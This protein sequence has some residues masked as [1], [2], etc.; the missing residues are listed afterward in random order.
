MRSS[1][2]LKTVQVNESNRDYGSNFIPCFFYTVHVRLL[3]IEYPVMTVV[4]SWRGIVRGD[5]LGLV[6]KLDAPTFVTYSSSF[7]SETFLRH[8]T[9]DKVVFFSKVRNVEEMSS[10]LNLQWV[11]WLKLLQNLL[12]NFFFFFF[13]FLWGQFIELWVVTNGY[14]DFQKE[15][16][17]FSN[18]FGREK[19]FQMFLHTVCVTIYN[20]FERRSVFTFLPVNDVMRKHLKSKVNDAFWK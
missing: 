20:I 15:K 8:V 12:H 1:D 2:W 10:R 19:N 14:R 9:D 11:W 7:C 3:N 18:T 6:S 17:Q 5:K 4:I 16:L 13:F